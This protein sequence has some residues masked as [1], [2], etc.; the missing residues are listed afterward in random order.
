MKATDIKIVHTR[1]HYRQQDI[2]V[3]MPATEENIAW[4]RMQCRRLKEDPAC[5]ADVKYK[6]RYSRPVSDL[7]RAALEKGFQ[8][9][10]LKGCVSQ[11]KGLYYRH[12]GKDSEGLR[13]LQSM[14]EI[15]INEQYRQAKEKLQCK[16]NT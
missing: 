1:P 11:L 9:R 16:K 15:S 6:I 12:Y 2:T 10:T 7:Q 3:W 14:L 13:Q 5:S 8:L 4:A